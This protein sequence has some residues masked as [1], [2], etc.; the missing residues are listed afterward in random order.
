MCFGS[1]PQ[2]PN[3]VYQGPSQAEIA[4]NQASLDAYK[5]QMTQQQGM[6]SAQLQSQIDAANK[7]TTD[8]RSKY[9][10]D[11]AAAAAAAAS[12]QTGAYAASATES[13]APT[14][15]QTTA[16]VMKKEKPKS[17]LRISTAGTPA[18]AGSGLNI[19]V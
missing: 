9:D 15:A 2:A 6:F 3:I 14:T 8:L 16:A 4:A 12:Q 18:A 19:G 10:Q 5:T 17:N 13:E 11:A 1:A 7:E